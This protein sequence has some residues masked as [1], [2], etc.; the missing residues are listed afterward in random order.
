MEVLY[1][2]KMSQQFSINSPEDLKTLLESRE[3]GLKEF[4]NDAIES[5]FDLLEFNLFISSI[6]KEKLDESTNLVRTLRKEVDEGK[7]DLIDY[8]NLAE[9]F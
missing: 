5:E 9:D 2:C 1:L 7:L 4:M 3:A 8:E 6:G